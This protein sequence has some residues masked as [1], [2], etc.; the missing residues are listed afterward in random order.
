VSRA[1][2]A[3][4]DEDIQHLLDGSDVGTKVGLT[5]LL[6]TVRPDGWPNLAL[7]SAGEVVVTSPSEVRLALWPSSTTTSNLRLQPKCT[8]A[9][10]HNNAAHYVHCLAAAQPDLV[11]A[12]G[13]VRSRFH[14]TVERHRVDVVGYATITSGITFEL[15]HE[16]E[17]VTSWQ[18]TVSLLRR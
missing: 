1:E 13:S 8:L 16:Q 15:A 14:L 10:V 6:V 12:R 2:S 5:V 11:L 17:T 7:L 9:L 18:E 3:V 4:V